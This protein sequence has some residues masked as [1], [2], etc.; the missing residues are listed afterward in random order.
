[1]PEIISPSNAK[2]F[3]LQM[4]EVIKQNVLHLACKQKR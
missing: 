4:T 2:P 3:K 1:M